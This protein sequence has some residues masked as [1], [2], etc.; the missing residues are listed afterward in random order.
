MKGIFESSSDTQQL[1]IPL[2]ENHGTL[3]NFKLAHQPAGILFLSHISQP[4]PNMVG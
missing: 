2:F 1:I 4:E 3:G